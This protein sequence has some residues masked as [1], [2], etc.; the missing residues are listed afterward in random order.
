MP[1]HESV[2]VDNAANVVQRTD[3]VAGLDGHTLRQARCAEVLLVEVDGPG[4]TTGH[5]AKRC[6]ERRSSTFRQVDKP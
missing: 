1:H 6:A 2:R 3:D 5:V 4:V